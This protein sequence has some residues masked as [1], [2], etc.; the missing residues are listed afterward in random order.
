MTSAWRSREVAKG[1]EHLLLVRSPR[2]QRPASGPRRVAQA[3]PRP[4][5]S[6]GGA[7]GP[8]SPGTSRPPGCGRSASTRC[9]SCRGRGRYSAP[10]APDREEPVL[11]RF[12]GP[13]VVSADLLGDAQRVLDVAA[14]ELGEGEGC[15][16]A[17]RGASAPRPSPRSLCRPPPH[18]R[19]ERGERMPPPNRFGIAVRA[20]A[21]VRCVRVVLMATRA[22]CGR[23]PRRPGRQGF[24]E[25]VT[26]PHQVE[27]V[28]ALEHTR[29]GL[30]A[31]TW[32]GDPDVAIHI[33]RGGVAARPA[34]E[35]AVA[36]P[37]AR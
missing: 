23:P 32:Q 10:A 11:D 18:Q 9:R 17:G 36:T 3:D 24:A 1:V 25:N 20:G 19:G 8:S 35:P 4:E 2:S 27:D 15:R 14:V 13:V 16:R 21:A 33:S 26:G 28:S 30:S 29:V 5:A 37:T 7:A 31:R 22:G 12:L 6:P 34:D